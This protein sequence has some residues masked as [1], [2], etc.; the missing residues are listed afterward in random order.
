MLAMH[1][2]TIS[3]KHLPGKN[4]SFQFSRMSLHLVPVLIHA[5]KEIRSSVHI[6]L[7]D[8]VSRGIFKIIQSC[9]LKDTSDLIY[10]FS[11]I[12]FKPPA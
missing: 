4:S 12:I 2:Y 10:S 3:F 11:N 7:F 6:Q 1:T 8:N 5:S 9:R